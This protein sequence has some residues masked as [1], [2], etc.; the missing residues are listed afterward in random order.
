MKQSL[1]HKTEVF[2][3]YERLYQI[4]KRCQNFLT[5]F[6]HLNNNLN[7]V[8]VFFVDVLVKGVDVDDSG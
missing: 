7:S 2:F 3:L 4:K 5:A 8:A 1:C 6:E